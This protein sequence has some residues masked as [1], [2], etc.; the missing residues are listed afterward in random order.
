[1]GACVKLNKVITMAVVILAGLWFFLVILLPQTFS[2]RLRPSNADN[3]LADDE[4]KPEMIT[5]FLYSSGIE[6]Y[7]YHTGTPRWSSSR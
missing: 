6:Y 2:I 5:H 4:W 3:E 7:T 1:M